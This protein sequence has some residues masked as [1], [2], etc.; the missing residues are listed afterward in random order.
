MGSFS[1]QLRVRRPRDEVFAA[2]LKSLDGPLNKI[3]FRLEQQDPQHVLWTRKA[4]GVQRLWSE[5]DR[6]TMSFAQ[7][8]NGETLVTIAGRAPAR[9]A[10]QFEQLEL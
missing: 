6:I 7:A 9:I 5:P 8:S 1:K 2:A 4:W 10:H 3:G